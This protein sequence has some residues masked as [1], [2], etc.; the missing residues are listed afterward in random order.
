MIKSMYH[1]IFQRKHESNAVDLT[2]T[3]SF[4]PFEEEVLYFS[5]P[6]FRCSEAVCTK[7][8]SEPTIWTDFHCVCHVRINQACSESY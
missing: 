5:T 6:H 4:S 2:S 3:Q 8:G 1:L 7:N